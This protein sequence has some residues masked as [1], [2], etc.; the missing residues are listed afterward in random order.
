MSKKRFNKIVEDIKKVKIQGAR[1]VAKAALYACSLYPGGC[2]I[3][4]EAKRKLESARPTEPMLT[5]TLH[6]YDK[7]G[8]KKTLEHFDEAQKKINSA[9]FKIIKNKMIIYTHCHSSNVVKALIYA[10][11]R[12]KKFEVFNTETRPLFQG[13]KTAKELGKEGIKVTMF[14]DS[15][16]EEAIS[17]A[18]LIFIGSDAILNSGVINKVGSELIGEIAN[19]RRKPMYVIADS[20]KFSPKHVKI[21]ERDFHEIWARVP[22]NIKVENPAFEFVHKKHIRGIV[23]EYGLLSFDKFIKKVRN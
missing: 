13:R 11:K 21:E 16:M 6:N 5:N 15:A 23:S 1:N 19:L 4:P 8:Y 18:D 10:K 14:A 22:K 9:V 3:H 20:W 2:L 7:L 12:G 17:K